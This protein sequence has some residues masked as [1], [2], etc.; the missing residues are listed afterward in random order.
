MLPL[1]M[2]TTRAL[3]LEPLDAAISPLGHYR[4]GESKS[5][6]HKIVAG[7]APISGAVSDAV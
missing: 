2:F 1:V 4:I 6:V 7:L 5:A 3:R